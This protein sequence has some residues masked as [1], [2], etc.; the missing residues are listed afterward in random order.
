MAADS[1]KAD[2][3]PEA[4]TPVIDSFGTDKHYLDCA[5]LGIEDYSTAGEC[6]QGGP[7]KTVRS[8]GWRSRAYTDVSTACFGRPA[9][10]ALLQNT[11]Y[12]E[13][14]TPE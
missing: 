4:G 12:K 14:A 10:R 2:L 6:A 8:H 11:E 3:S 7:S 13:S 9:L 1:H 5:R